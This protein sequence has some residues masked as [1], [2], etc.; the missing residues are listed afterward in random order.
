MDDNELYDFSKPTSEK[1][2]KRLDVV[3]FVAIISYFPALISSY[4][5]LKFYAI[6]SIFVFAFLA[7][8]C[9]K[10][11]VATLKDDGEKEK[12]KEND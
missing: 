11:P 9:Y 7:L 1:V 5:G 12:E 10:T 3:L 8:L 4:M 6:C 2:K